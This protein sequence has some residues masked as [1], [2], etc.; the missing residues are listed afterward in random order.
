M[1]FMEKNPLALKAWKAA[2]KGGRIASRAA[3]LL[4][5]PDGPRYTGLRKSGEEAVPAGAHPSQQ[6]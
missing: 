3:R 1:R 5:N 4:A 2:R 6:S